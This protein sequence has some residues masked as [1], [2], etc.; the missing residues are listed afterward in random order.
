MGIV[1]IG[2]ILKYE[3]YEEIY[4]RVVCLTHRKSAEA[5][6][7]KA[8]TYKENAETELMKA[9]GQEENN[10]ISGKPFKFSLILD[11][12]KILN[13]FES[14]EFIFNVSFLNESAEIAFSEH[15]IIIK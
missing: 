3:V 5:E 12:E 10:M 1:R 14:V 15:R 8:F 6:L 2:S 9:I 13:N 4:N 7:I 11:N